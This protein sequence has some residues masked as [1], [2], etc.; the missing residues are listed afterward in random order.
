MGGTMTISLTDDHVRQLRLHA[1]KL[2][3]QQPDSRASVVQLV[4]ELGGIQAQDPRAATLAVRV[5]TVGLVA[6]DVE[7]ARI[8]ERS[9]VRT[10]GLRGTLHLLAAEDL[11]W[12]L[13]L[14]GPVFVARDR[15]RRA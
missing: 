6:A 8:Q 3:R 1:Q 10:W 11:G 12:L 4:R 13:P 7:H 2:A 5:R 15:R 14:L 9:V